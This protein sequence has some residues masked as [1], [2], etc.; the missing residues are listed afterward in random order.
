LQK[1]KVAETPERILLAV[2]GSDNSKRASKAAI[3]LAKV[4]GAELSVVHVI[5][6]LSYFS[7]GVVGISSTTNN[8]YKQYY[9]ITENQGK[10]WIDDILSEARVDGVKAQGEILRPTSSIAYS[11]LRKAEKDNSDLIVIGT[12]GLG[13]FKKLLLGSVS[14]GVIGHSKCNVLIIK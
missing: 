5:P 6:T 3:T 4:F 7:V 12:R 14:S 10:H 11:I 1:S 9:E 8:Y 2:D 13:G